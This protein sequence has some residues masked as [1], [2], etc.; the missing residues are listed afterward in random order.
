M[1]RTIA[2]VLLPLVLASS[3]SVVTSPGTLSVPRAG[4]LTVAKP[5]VVIKVNP[6]HHLFEYASGDTKYEVTYSSKTEWSARLEQNLSAG[7]HV[8]VKGRLAGSTIAAR[9]VVN[10]PGPERAACVSDAN[11]VD[12]AVAA[13]ETENS[14]KAPPTVKSL[15]TKAGGGPY[16]QQV[17]ENS[18]FFRIALNWGGAS[19]GRE[20]GGKHPGEADVAPVWIGTVGAYVSFLGEGPNTGCNAA[21]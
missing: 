17:P 4:T 5:G 18:A 20:N 15:T 1:H 10:N 19:P 2:A 8:I 13:Y 16:L 6:K 3:Q 11:I 12:T 14:G 7:W 9:K 21:T